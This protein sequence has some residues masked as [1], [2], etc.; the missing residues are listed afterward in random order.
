VL[1]LFA[2]LESALAKSTRALAQATEQREA[3]HAAMSEAISAFCRVFGFGD[4]PSGSSPQSRLQALGDHVR[5]RLCERYITAS[6]GP[7]PCLLP[8]TSWI[9]S[10]SA[11]GIASLTKMKP[12]WLK[13]RG[14]T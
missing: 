13:S 4:V 2:E 1:W 7:S 3:D 12:P 6:G 14:S 11:R 10:G 5:G 9:W 8:T